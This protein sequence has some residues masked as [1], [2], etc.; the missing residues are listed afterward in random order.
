MSWPA[1]SGEASGADQADV[2]A[3]GGGDHLGMR[4]VCAASQGP[5]VSVFSRPADQL[6]GLAQAA[7]DHEDGRVEDRGEIREGLPD[8]ASG[9][10]EQVHREQVAGPGCLGDVAGLDARWRAI[11]QRQEGG[12]AVRV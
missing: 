10:L 2:L 3:Y 5:S 1:T 11:A 4:S 8:P 12:R 9:L 6:P 7:A